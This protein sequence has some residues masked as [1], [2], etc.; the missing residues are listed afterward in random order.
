VDDGS[1]DRSA[2]IVERDFPS[3]RLVRSHHSGV[4]AARNLGTR[5]AVGLFLQYLD[6]DD[7]LAPGKIERQLRA[8]EESEADVAYG[9]WQKLV[10]TKDGTYTDGEVIARKLNNP[11]IDLVTDFWC[12]PAAYLFRRSI[13]ERIRGWNESL[14][15]I[16]DARFALDCAL[17]GAKFVYCPG[18]MARYRVHA[19]GSVSTR[20][21]QAFVR[22]CLHNALDVEGWW[23]GHGGVSVERR[24]ALASV[25][26]YVARA[27]FERDRPTFEAAYAAL[28]RVAPGYVPDHPRH[29]ALASRAIG[30]RRAEQMAL[31]YRRLT[32]LLPVAGSRSAAT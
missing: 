21:P 11:E 3:V 1:T 18:I 25:Y 14:P 22:D 19:S 10:R 20:D 27:S 5:L 31:W 23:G 7:L 17:H 15:V 9:D 6:A 30:Y 2:S 16:Q 24:N 29:L 32:K 26:G 13:V 28:E 4:S 12:P 8:L